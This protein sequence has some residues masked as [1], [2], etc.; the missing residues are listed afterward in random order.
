VIGFLLSEAWR[1]MPPE[2]WSMTHAPA[3]HP[4]ISTGR[5][6]TLSQIHYATWIKGE[7]SKIAPNCQICAIGGGFV[8]G[9]KTREFMTTRIYDDA[10]L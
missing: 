8:L 1:K 5:K 7:S 6:A 2:R 3:A 4:T 9:A 10:N